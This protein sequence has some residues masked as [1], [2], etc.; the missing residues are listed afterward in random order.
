M[1]AE[2]SMHIIVIL[3]TFVENNVAECFLSRGLPE[4]TRIACLSFIL[5]YRSEVSIKRATIQ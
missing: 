5:N 1:V 4:N 3:I 2:G